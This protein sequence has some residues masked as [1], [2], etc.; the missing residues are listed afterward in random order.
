MPPALLSTRPPTANVTSMTSIV[1][2]VEPST[3]AAVVAEAARLAA[4]LGV[5]L[6]CVHAESGRWVTEKL[7]DNV[8]EARQRLEPDFAARLDAQL[9]GTGV[10]Q[11]QQLSLAG[12]PAK[13]LAAVAASAG[14]RMIVV[15]AR[16][17]GLRSRFEEL[18]DGSI[19]VA[20]AT[21]QPVPVLVVPSQPQ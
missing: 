3:P 9:E 1:V 4:G 2:G 13:V 20:L 10:D 18:L 15:G 7:P 21:R 17:P 8:L 11:V 16:R 5:A 14:A 19:A 6:W 12:D